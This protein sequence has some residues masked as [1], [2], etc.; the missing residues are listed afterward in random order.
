MCKPI[1]LLIADNDTLFSK[2][3]N[4]F[5]DKEEDIRVVNL[6]RDGHGVLNACKESLPDVV[7]IDLHLPVLDSIK[8]IQ[9]V[10]AQNEHI[11]ILGISSIPDD[12]Y[13]VAAIKVGAHGYVEKN[14]PDSYEVIASAIRQVAVGEVVLNS[15]L[16]SHILREFSE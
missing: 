12:R 7:L 15:T 6:V 11:K 10:V 2:A 3:F 16:A 9:S 4:D 13:A 1:R 5:L 8:T 14:G